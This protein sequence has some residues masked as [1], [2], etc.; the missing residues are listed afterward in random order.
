MRF[1]EGR[2][3]DRQGF[4]DIDSPANIRGEILAEA[5]VVVLESVSLETTE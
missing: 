2:G 5:R 3:R 1:A 4:A